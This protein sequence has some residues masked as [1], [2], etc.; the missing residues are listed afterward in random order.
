M[1]INQILN[2]NLLFVKLGFQVYRRINHSTRNMVRLIFIL[3]PYSATNAGIFPL[4][5]QSD[6]GHY[7]PKY[8]VMLQ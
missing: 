5:K 3:P 1:L 6:D 7:R 4:S 2:V 8:V